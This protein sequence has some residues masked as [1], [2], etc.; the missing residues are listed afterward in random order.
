[1]SATKAFF[2]LH[3]NSQIP[4]S[5]NSSFLRVKLTNEVQKA[6]KRGGGDG[7]VTINA[8]LKAELKLNVKQLRFIVHVFLLVKACVEHRS[9]PWGCWRRG[10]EVWK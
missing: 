8:I 3:G 5:K 1:M 4:Q 7:L 9:G 10:A 6:L 2:K